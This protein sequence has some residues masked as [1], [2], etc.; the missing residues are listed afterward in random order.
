MTDEAR[1]DALSYIARDKGLCLIRLADG[2]FALARYERTGATLD[3]IENYLR[4]DGSREADYGREQERRR[5]EWEILKSQ[6]E[7]FRR[8]EQEQADRIRAGERVRG[9]AQRGVGPMST[10]SEKYLN[11][12]GGSAGV[13]SR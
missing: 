3:E 7:W 2:S 10:P 6:I 5:A 9:V 1:E 8:H 4:S 13:S 12:N 11:P